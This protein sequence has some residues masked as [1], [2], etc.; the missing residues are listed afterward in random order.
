MLRPIS[1]LKPRPSATM[2]MPTAM[3][4]L[5]VRACDA[6]K[7]VARRRPRVSRAVR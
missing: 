1:Q 4:P 6:V 2:A 5:R 3:M 7:R